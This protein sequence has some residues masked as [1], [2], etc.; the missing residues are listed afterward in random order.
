MEP[1]NTVAERIKQ[2]AHDLF[3]QFGLRSVSMDDIATA[4][5]VSKKTIYQY[6][7]DKDALANEVIADL[8]NGN[9]C[10]CEA[11]VK[12]SKNAIHELFLAMEF[13]TEMF[14]KMN[15]S[16]LFD[17]QKYHPEAFS[18]F[19]K[20][21]N[22]YIYNMVMANIKRGIAEGLYRDDFNAEVIT[23]FR[24]S[25]MMIS[26]NPEFHNSVKLDVSTIEEELLL[27]FLYGMVSPK[28]Y[29]LINKYKE[30]RKN[31]DK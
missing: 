6:Y 8:L 14:S 15:P 1:I 26:F 12:A 24:V 18:N 2:K 30:E 4:L 27:Y 20:F 3:M 11:D 25:S 28:G 13:M 22:D 21:K 29:K 7:A 17:L 31:N 10:R 16:L 23:R 9:M 19:L 5:G